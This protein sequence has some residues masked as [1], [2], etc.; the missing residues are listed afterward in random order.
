MTKKFELT[1]ETRRH[2]GR[3]LYR[4]R[5]LMSFGNVNAGDLGGWVE[6]EENLSQ[7]G[8]ARVYGNARVKRGEYRET[9]I[10]I[11]RSDGYTFTMQSDGSVVAGCRDFTPEEAH[12]HWGDPNHHKH[13]ESMAIVNALRAISKARE[14]A[15]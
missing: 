10:N 1:S 5:A 14:A 3:T 8:T 9:P 11:T 7:D 12:A 2:L 15:K 4:I 6:R 13:R